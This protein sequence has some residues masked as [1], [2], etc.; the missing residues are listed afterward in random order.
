M[1][2]STGT[3]YTD[4]Y[5]ELMD[6]SKFLVQA[7]EQGPGATVNSVATGGPA[8]VKA[9]V[10]VVLDSG[11]RMVLVKALNSPAI[12]GWVRA[13][14]EEVLYGTSKQSPALFRYLH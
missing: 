4:K 6:K 14:I 3:N 13:I 5:G 11:N 9:L 2:G 1:T 7:I 12:A 8:S 10:D